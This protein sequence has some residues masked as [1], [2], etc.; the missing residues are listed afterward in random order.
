MVLTDMLTKSCPTEIHQ[1]QRRSE[2]LMAYKKEALP[3]GIKT[4]EDGTNKLVTRGEFG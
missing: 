4:K 3:N 1:T 2:N